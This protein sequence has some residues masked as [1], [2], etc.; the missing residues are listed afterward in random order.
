MRIVQE[1]GGRIIN[2]L[3]MGDSIVITGLGINLRKNNYYY[4]RDNILER[5][6]QMP[7]KEEYVSELELRIKEEKEKAL[8]SYIKY[9][10]LQG[11][12]NIEYLEFNRIT[13]IIDDLERRLNDAQ[14]EA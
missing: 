6:I 12:A 14:K 11:E 2:I 10:D 4:S 13:V 5:S 8:R 7:T 1:I 9:K 3:D